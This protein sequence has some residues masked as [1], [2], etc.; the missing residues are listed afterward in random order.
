MNCSI[1]I[2]IKDVAM[3]ENC[4]YNTARRRLQILHSCLSKERHQ[5]VTLQEYCN[6]EGISVEAFNAAIKPQFVK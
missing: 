4:H 6:Y 3:V 5:R 1:F 2:S